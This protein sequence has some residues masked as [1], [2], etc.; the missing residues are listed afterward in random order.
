MRYLLSGILLALVC[1]PLL[2]EDVELIYRDGVWVQ[3]PPPA[4]GTPEGESAIVRRDLKQQNFALAVEHANRFLSRYGGSPLR[5]EVMF[6]AGNAELAQKRYWQ[7]YQWYERQLKDFPGGNYS[8]QAMAKEM[9]VAGAF[10]AGAKRPTLGVFMVSAQDEGLDILHKIAER[11]PNSDRAELALLAVAEYYVKDHRYEQA[12]EAYD[13]FLRLF[14]KSPRAPQAEYAAADSYLRDYRG[15]SFDETPLIEAQQRFKAFAEHY[16][17]ASRQHDVDAVLGR[18]LD[19]RAARL[20]QTTQFYL[21]L[22]HPTAAAEYCR[23]LL[24]EYPDSAYASSAQRTLDRLENRPALPVSPAPAPANV[25]ANA[26][27]TQPYAKEKL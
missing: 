7:A 20:Y 12:A 11:A 27:S 8:D 2:S 23:I 19:L 14:P 15:A 17:A 25:P 1:A 5:E 6:Q 26:P 21:K 4:E 13:A 3:L 24:R 9:E 10:L 18:I 22:D 16:P